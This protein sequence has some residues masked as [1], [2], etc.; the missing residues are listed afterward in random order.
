MAVVCAQGYHI[1]KGTLVL[2][3]IWAAHHDA[4]V[5]PQ[6]QQFRPDRFLGSHTGVGAAAGA[7]TL[8]PFGIGMRQ[9]TGMNLGMQEVR[10]CAQQFP[11]RPA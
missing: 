1:P 3:N 7:A 5:H 8:L 11:A 10:V 9:C 2:S 6:P 4:A